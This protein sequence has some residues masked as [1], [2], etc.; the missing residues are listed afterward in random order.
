MVTLL[1]ASIAIF[2][3]PGPT[4]TILIVMLSLILIDSPCFRD[5]TNIANLLALFIRPL[6]A[7]GLREQYRQAGSLQTPIR[8]N[9]CRI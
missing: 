4:F 8:K 3:R 7:S 9:L 5:N 2:T 6:T 1:G